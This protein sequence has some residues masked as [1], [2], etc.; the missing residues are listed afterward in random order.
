MQVFKR[1]SSDALL[2]L[3]SLLIAF[4]IWIIAKRGDMTQETY[5]VSL[6]LKNTP[7]NVMT[8][9]DRRSINLTLPIPNQLRSR[10]Q[11]DIFRAEIDFAREKE[12]EDPNKWCGLEDYRPSQKI[13]VETRHIKIQSNDPDLL[14]R[15]QRQLQY[16]SIH[17]GEVT[18]FGQLIN[19]PARIVFRTKGKPMAGFKLKD[20]EASVAGNIRLT[21]SPAT[22]A[23]L[24][25]ED[26]SPVPIET[27]EIDL[28]GRASDFTQTVS[29]RIPQDMELV[30][31]EDRRIEVQVSLEEITRMVEN[32]PVIFPPEQDNYKA[33]LTPSVVSIRVRGPEDELESLTKEYFSVRPSTSVVPENGL[34]QTSALTASASGDMPREISESISVRTISPEQVTIRFTKP[35]KPATVRGM[36]AGTTATS[37]ITTTT[38]PAL[39]PDDGSSPITTNPS[40]PAPG[41]IP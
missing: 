41:V 36:D 22:F 40:P 3:A 25:P 17:F 23:S 15:L 18:V 27:E 24:A 31:A 20:I 9:L 1:L 21:A 14:Q 6:S 37:S 8:R 12:L 16:A 35:E 29:L 26:G 39:P 32:V 4:A 38:E 13:N 11:S 10:I 34:E 2:I 28:E 30:Y 5:I 7:D 33:E 19:R